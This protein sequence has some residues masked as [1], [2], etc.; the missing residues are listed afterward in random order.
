MGVKT[1]LVVLICFFL[2]RSHAKNCVKEE[3]L[4]N[5]TLCD[6]TLVPESWEDA[7]YTVV[8]LSRNEITQ[9][10]QF[11]YSESIKS[12]IL[13]HN[14]VSEI[15]TKAFSELINL[16][17]IDLSFNYLTYTALSPLVFQGRASKDEYEPLYVEILYLGHNSLHALGARAF[18]H[19]PSLAELYLDHNPFNVLD[20]VTISAITNAQRNLRV[21]D[22]SYC[23]LDSIPEGFLHTLSHLE[24]L[25]LNGNQFINI[26]ATLSEASK[27]LIQLSIDDNPL[28]QTMFP[29]IKNLQVLNMSMIDTFDLISTGSFKNLPALRIFTCTSNAALRKIEQNAFSLQENLTEVRIYFFK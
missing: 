5:C 20:A 13:S 19:L 11:P 23:G 14:N 29:E 27:S 3:E 22:F 16:K 9:I 28:E 6:L 26:P 8:D 12:L 18:E 10:T 2:S 4:L 17:L 1:L 15:E 25:F 21:L 24:T 7:N